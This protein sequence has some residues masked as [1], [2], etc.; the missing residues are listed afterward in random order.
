[1]RRPLIGITCS[2]ESEVQGERYPSRLA[3]DFLKRNY[4]QAV[5]LAGGIPIALPNSESL[6]NI[7]DLLA[8][9]DGV[10]FSGG[11][12]VAPHFYGEEICTSNLDIALQRDQFELDL[13]RQ[14]R[15]ADL[16]VLGICRGLQLLNVAFGGTLYQDL[17]MNP[18]VSFNHAQGGGGDY[19]VRHTVTLQPESRLFKIVRKDLLWVN[20]SH[21]QVIKRLAPDLS[22]GAVSSDDGV[23]EAVEIPQAT[24]FLCVQWHPEAMILDESSRLLFAAFVQ[25]ARSSRK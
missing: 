2:A 19:K 7:P 21:H 9:L 13:A 25:T 6:E 5:E 1:M 8:R 14:A 16:P 10:L 23:I 15:L 18:A 11:E 20:T 22:V 12:D 17:S 4:C 24:F 3:F